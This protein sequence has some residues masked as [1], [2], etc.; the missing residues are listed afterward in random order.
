MAELFK[1]GSVQEND[2]PK[3]PVEY[4]KGYVF[5]TQCGHK[6]EMNSTE[7]GERIRLMNCHG[8]FID[9][10]EDGHIYIMANEDII[11]RA[12]GNMA[13]KVGGD[14]KEDKLV[15]HVV[16]NAH[17]TVEGDMHTETRG[18]RYDKVDGTWEMKAGEVMF[19]QSDENIAVKAE[20]RLELN[21]NSINQKMTFAKNDLSE[22]GEI[23][24]VI[25]GNRVIE[26]SKEGGVFAILSKGDLQIR[27]EGCRYDTVGTNYFT[28]V[29]GKMKTSVVGDD[30]D[31]ITGGV[32]DGGSWTRKPADSPY[33][34]PTAWQVNA[35]EGARIVSTDMHLNA[36]E[37]IKIQAAGDEVKIECDNGIYLN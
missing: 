28:N 13:V 18:N 36:T 24:D 26:M 7:G 16:G 10:D 30:L 19:L 15:I 23:R 32:T 22:G 25:K 34:N 29:E 6:I 4:P 33:G 3:I 11:A 17:M 31:C 14:I 8:H 5:N 1:G 9:I 21:A 2:T 12:P 27:A 35:G 37:N 20:N